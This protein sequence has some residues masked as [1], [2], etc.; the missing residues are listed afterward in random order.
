[1]KIKLNKLIKNILK[2]MLFV[3]LHNT[4]T[5]ADYVCFEFENFPGQHNKQKKLLN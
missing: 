3:N 1:M 2:N 4:A 5:M